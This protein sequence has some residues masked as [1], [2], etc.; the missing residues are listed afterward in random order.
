MKQYIGISRDHSGSMAGIR[1]AAMSDYNDN[2]ESIRTAA[3]DHD[4]DTIISTVRCGGDVQ[5]EAVNSSVAALKPLADYR[6]DGQTPL[7]DSVGELISLLEQVPDRDDPTVSFLVMAIT[8][9]EENASRKFNATALA[10]K[11]RNL[12]ATDRWTFVF[13]VPH[14][15]SSQLRRLGIP[16][17]NIQEWDGTTEKS[18]REGTTVTRQAFTNYYAQRAKGVRAT[19]SFYTNLSNVKSST[20]KKLLTDI[21]DNVEIFEVKRTAQIRDFVEY[22][23]GKSLVLG[24]AFY[25]LMKPEKVVK[26]TKLICLRDRTTGKIYSGAE[27]RDLLGLPRDGTV[28]LKPGDHGN[29]DIFIQSASVNR[30]LMPG[31]KVL[32]W[33]TMSHAPTW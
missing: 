20:V 33:P 18:L 22:K 30:K 31:T 16:D 32:Y 29:Y 25:E 28:S 11:I 4:I 15:Y 24:T 2:V 14:G 9:G 27:A 26:S 21:S 8:D 1:K 19:D 5:R 17:G 7:F 13:R 12:V 10:D 3:K 23:T 6:A